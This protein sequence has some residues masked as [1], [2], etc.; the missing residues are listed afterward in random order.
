MQSGIQLVCAMWVMATLSLALVALRLYT[1]IRIVKFVGA[2]DYM[3]A[4]TGV[5]S[6]SIRVHMFFRCFTIFI[7]V[8]VHYGL[9]HNSFW[10][11]ILNDTSNAIL[12]TYVANIQ[13]RWHNIALWTAVVITSATSIALTI[14]LWNQTPPVKTSWD[15]LYTPGTWILQ[16]QPMSIGLGVWSSIC[17]F[18]FAIFKFKLA[19][20]MSLAGAEIAV[21]MATASLHRYLKVRRLKR[22]RSSYTG[23]LPRFAEDQK[24]TYKL[25]STC[26]RIYVQTQ[27]HGSQRIE[28]GS[29]IHQS[30]DLSDGVDEIISEYENH[31]DG[32]VWVR[33]AIRV[34]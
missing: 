3:Y 21:A 32:A 15:V 22:G 26:A 6:N 16:I 1:R 24:A 14:M 9:G 28:A 27:R 10:H 11:L 4:C 33:N 34:T 13:A 12:W 25:T 30:T 8:A 7:Q 19:G 17:D 31:H 29:G 20:G 2:E 5:V 23:G 18:F